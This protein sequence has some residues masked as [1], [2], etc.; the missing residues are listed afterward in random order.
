MSRVLV[1]DD[2][3]HVREAIKLVLERTGYDVS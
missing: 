1:I 3:P 2:A